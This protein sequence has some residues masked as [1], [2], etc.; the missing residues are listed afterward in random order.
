M[1]SSVESLSKLERK[2]SVQVPEPTVKEAFLKA[3]RE[4]QKEATVKGFRKGKAPLATIRSMYM[5]RVKENVIQDLVQKHYSEALAE[6]SLEPI[7]F[8]HIDFEDISDATEFNFT[9]SFEVR[10]EVELKKIKDLKVQREIFAVSEEQIER[11]LEQMREGRTEMRP[12]LEERG[13][14]N[15]DVAVVDF[16]G[17][18]AGEP[19]E[20]GSATDHQ[21]EIGSNTFI[22]G[23]EEGLVGLKVGEE[24][25]ISL[26]FPETYHVEDLAGKPVEFKVTLKD[27][28][29]KVLPELNDE[30][31]KSLGG[32]YETLEDLKKAISEDISSS[33]QRRIEEDLKNRLL[34]ALVEENPVEVPPSLLQNQK[35]ALIDDFKQRLSQQGFGEKEF[36]EYKEK[37]DHDFDDTARFMIQSSFLI[38]QIAETENLIPTAEDVDAKIK[39]YAAQTG[40]EEDKIREFYSQDSRSGQ[41]VYQIKEK[42]VIDFLLG[43]SQIEDVPAEEL[44]KSESADDDTGA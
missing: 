5:D 43:Q 3:F 24:R 17:F 35:Q 1:K 33:E 30:F 26:A 9:A 11:S 6:H 40:L 37:W 21:L 41:L 19:L 38:D 12:M 4:L 16:Q 34:R 20:N 32:T 14:Q 13:L 22:P 28:K 31:A 44:R 2:L 15:G 25:T 10:P 29:R 8:P 39:E 23:F 7:S 36:S 18:M 27:I 42:K